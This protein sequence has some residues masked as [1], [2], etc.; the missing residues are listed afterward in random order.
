[1]ATLQ[2]MADQTAF[3]RAQS[4]SRKKKYTDLRLMET[5]MYRLPAGFMG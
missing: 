3:E 2:M 1:M 5:Q 4:F